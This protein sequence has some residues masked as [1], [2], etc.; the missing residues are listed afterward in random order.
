MRKDLRKFLIVGILEQIANLVELF[1]EVRHCGLF[2][3]SPGA[4][5]ANTDDSLQEVVV[6]KVAWVKAV[7]LGESLF[8]LNLCEYELL[9]L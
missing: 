9:S 6:V 4:S 1:I 5:L 7:R 8:D 3:L 2:L